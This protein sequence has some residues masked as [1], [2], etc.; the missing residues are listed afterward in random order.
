MQFL[1]LRATKH[2]FFSGS[3]LKTEVFR[4]AL[5]LVVY[6]GGN[7]QDNLFSSIFRF[8]QSKQRTP[9]EDYCTE[10]FVY[11]LRQS[12]GAKSDLA[13]KFLAL[14]GF[15]NLSV[16]HLENIDITT[17]ET[18]WVGDKRVIPDIIIKS[19]DK[20]NVIE[21]K[22]NSGLRRYDSIKKKKTIDQIEAYKSITDIKIND[23]F[24]LSKYVVLSDSLDNKHKILWS[25]IHSL[26]ANNENEITKNFALFL[27]ENGMKSMLVQDNEVENAINAIFSFLNLIYLSWQASAV[28]K[29]Y[30]LNSDAITQ[31][32]AGW[33]VGDNI[34]WIGQYVETKEYLVFELLDEN[35]IMKAKKICRERNEENE[36]FEELSDGTYYLAK[37][38]IKD[39]SSQKNEKEQ[40]E[41]LQKW[42]KDKIEIFLL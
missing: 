28:N 34:A 3:L 10:I 38:K 17:R 36:G 23:I 41:V 19:P 14:F 27:E 2:A 1:A 25:E 29:K 30:P 24:S 15:S 42:I 37:I 32:S 9:L 18:H 39:I 4:S 31:V 26:L 12:I 7:M 21:V 22:I 8:K 33:F 35:L 20:I 40:R 13:H 6:Q 16:A 11:I 5:K